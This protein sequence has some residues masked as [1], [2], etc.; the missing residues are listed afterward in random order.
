MNDPN[1]S[2]YINEEAAV[3]NKEMGHPCDEEGWY[4]VGET[5]DG[6]FQMFGPFTDWTCT[7]YKNVLGI[8]Y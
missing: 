3:A 6:Y 5:Q 1:E 8:V 7:V 2:F 4:Y